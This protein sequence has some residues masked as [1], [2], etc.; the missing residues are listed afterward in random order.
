MSIADRICFDLGMTNRQLLDLASSTTDKYHCF[1][2]GGR[3]IVAPRPDLKLVQCWISDYINTE[4][5]IDLPYATAYEKG[6][7]VCRNARLHASSSH[8]LL[9]DIRHFFESCTQKMVRNLISGGTYR[10][11]NAESRSR[12]T[13]DDVE[14][15]V[16][17]SCY[18]GSLATGSPCSPFIANRIMASFDHEISARLGEK[19]VYSRYSDDICISSSEWINSAEISTFVGSRLRQRGFD[20]NSD[21]TRCFGRGCLRK[22][23]GIYLDCDGFLRLGPQR[24]AELKGSLYHVLMCEC[25]RECALRVLGHLSFCKQVEPD[26][27]NALLAKYASYGKAVSSG[28]VM[29]ALVELAY[30]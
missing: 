15:L 7:S 5:D 17:L 22:I 6:S 3:K 2:A 20:L 18:R 8:F 21:K 30:R 1:S 23:T 25:D 26:Y 28:G 11:T 27:C 29:P 10:P 13:A 12:L 24:K 14:L 19:F 4:F 9:L 16:A